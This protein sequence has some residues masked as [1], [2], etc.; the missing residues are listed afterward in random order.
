M[1]ASNTIL[2][3]RYRIVRV[4]LESVYVPKVLCSAALFLV[5]WLHVRDERDRPRGGG[6]RSRSRSS[7]GTNA[8]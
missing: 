7:C 6:S 3:N 8:R 4:G 5:E 1:R 2:Q